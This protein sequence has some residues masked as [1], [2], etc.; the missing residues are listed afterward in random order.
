MAPRGGTPDSFA[1]AAGPAVAQAPP[2]TA[3]AAPPR[4]RSAEPSPRDRQQQ[5]LAAAAAAASEQLAA[6]MAAT[7]KAPRSSVEFESTWRAL[8]GDAA[9]QAQYLSLLPAAQLPTIFKDSLTA[10]VLLAITRAALAAV[11]APPNTAAAGGG[12]E[13]ASTPAG[14]APAAAAELVAG[15]TR[16]PRF[17]MMAMCIGSRDKTELKA[18]WDAAAAALDG[19]P[20]ERLLAARGAF[21]V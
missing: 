15:L 14:L 1:A 11:V 3:P 2:A 21:R 18:L 13:G 19:A 8:K 16:V 20:A 6:R 12:A 5:R 7:L 17:P 4:P 9:L 10:P